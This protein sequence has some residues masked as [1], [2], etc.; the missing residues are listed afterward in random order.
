MFP[1]GAFDALNAPDNETQL[2]LGQPPKESCTKA[3]VCE[4]YEKSLPKVVKYFFSGRF[5]VG[6][7][8]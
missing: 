2:T 3:K 1:K 5:E 6:V 7:V 4:K 8:S